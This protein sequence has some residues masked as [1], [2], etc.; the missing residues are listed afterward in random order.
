MK[1]WKRAAAVIGGI[2]ILAFTGADLAEASNEASL[3]GVRTDQVEEVIVTART[4]PALNLK[5]AGS[6]GTHLDLVATS[7]APGARGV[8][9]I[10]SK[11][12]YVQVQAS[13]RGLPQ[14]SSFGSELTTYV[15]W[16]ITP[17]GRTTNMGEFVVQGPGDRVRL[18]VTS[19]LPTFGMIVT[20]EPHFAVTM[21]SDLV[22]LEA[23]PRRGTEGRIEEVEANYELLDRGHYA[24]Q[25]AGSLA[26]KAEADNLDYYVSQARNAS[27]IA[28]MAGADRYAPEL[29]EDALDQ[30]RRAQQDGRVK[31]QVSL[32]RQAVQGFEDARLVA[33]ERADEIRL[34][35]AEEEAVEARTRAERAQ[36]RA[37]EAEREKARLRAELTRRLSQV[38]ETRESERGLV[39]TIPDLLFETNE[40]EL[41]PGAKEKLRRVAEVLEE[42]PEIFLQVEGHTDS[43]GTEA[44]NR[45]LSRLRARSV[46]DFLV[47]QGISPTRIETRGYGESRPI[48]PNETEYGMQQNRRV[49]IV[50]SGEPI[51]IASSS[52]VEGDQ[53]SRTYGSSR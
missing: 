2:G 26:V 28:R 47:Q 44:Y 43:R 36:Q 35:R 16:A 9:D 23:R 3:R 18:E 21:P 6:V 45:S 19:E 10:D 14:A 53:A 50:V 1:H 4:I 41:E 49:E 32:A 25:G 37:E 51:G 11:K 40:Y 46:R 15:L 5:E 12:G 27:R 13:L 30:L 29:F 8:I 39:V 22:V 52:R 31:M 20:A 7:K 24:F 17:Q 48:A 38:L 34:A 33:R 42:D